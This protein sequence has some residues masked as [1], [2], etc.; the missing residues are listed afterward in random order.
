MMSWIA[1]YRESPIERLRRQAFL[2]GQSVILTNTN[3]Q[4]FLHDVLN[5]MPIRNNR[6]SN[7][8]CIQFTFHHASQ[9]I[10]GVNALWKNDSARKER[11]ICISDS[12]YDIGFDKGRESEAKWLQRGLL[13]RLYS[14]D[15]FNTALDRCSGILKKRFSRRSRSCARPVSLENL[16]IEYVFDLADS[17]TDG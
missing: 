15:D 3:H 12:L 11:L 4:S 14:L 9:S 17:S 13:N 5:A 7:K 1:E 8:N 10:A 16:D 2:S 6:K